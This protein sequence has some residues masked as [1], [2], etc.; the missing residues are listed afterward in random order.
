MPKSQVPPDVPEMTPP[1]P[2]CNKPMKLMRLEPAEPGHDL[3]MFECQCGH[4]E[5]RKVAYK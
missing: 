3:R 2:A 1:C 4:S 5:T